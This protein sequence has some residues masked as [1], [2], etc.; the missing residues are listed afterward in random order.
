MLKSQFDINF[1]VQ[2]L[3]GFE[4]QLKR[5]GNATAGRV[6]RGGAKSAMNKIFRP[7]VAAAPVGPRRNMRKAIKLTSFSGRGGFAA[8]AGI[9]V[10]RGTAPHWHLIEFG[11]Q[12]RRHR[13]GKGR[14]TGRTPANPFFRRSMDNNT[15][16]AIEQFKRFMQRRI[17]KE[18]AKR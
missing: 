18:M 7:T 14:T 9:Y 16:A 10:R 12:Q 17:A 1:D 8:V 3:T 5:L 6:L 15:G 13:G 4:K 2:G 11:T